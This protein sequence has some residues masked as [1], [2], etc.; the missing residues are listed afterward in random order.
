VPGIS[1]AVTD[2]NTVIKSKFGNRT[3][4]KNI[5]LFIALLVI[6]NQA[7]TWILQIDMTLLR[8][9]STSI[10]IALFLHPIVMHQFR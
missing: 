4:L 6:G 2:N 5:I 8:E 9:V 7:L 10:L 1:P 3:M